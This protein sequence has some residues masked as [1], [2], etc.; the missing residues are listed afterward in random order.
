MPEPDVRIWVLDTSSIIQVRRLHNLPASKQREILI[1]I[2]ELV[3]HDVVVYPR[4]VLAELER[5]CEG[6]QP[7]ERFLWAK[8][9]SEKACRF[10]AEFERVVHVLAR[11][12]SV[13]DTEK[14]TGAEEADPYVIALALTLREWGRDVTVVTEDRV[15]K[16]GK[17]SLGTACGLCGIPTVPLEAFLAH[18]TI[19]TRSGGS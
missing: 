12:P 13:V 16:P 1:S 17:M 6:K 5:A 7:D 4:E 15:D 14:T 9:H 2:G 8:N 18:L 10:G 3:E 19:W 11:V